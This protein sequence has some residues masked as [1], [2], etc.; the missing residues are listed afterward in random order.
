[1]ARKKV[2]S[3]VM[4][5]ESSRIERKAS[6]IDAEHL[7]GQQVADVGDLL[8]VA[9][10]PVGDAEHRGPEAAADDDRH[11]RLGRAIP[12]APAGVARAPR[13]TWA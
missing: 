2:D 7:A 13:A 1:M 11:Q 6:R 3:A 10:H 12:A 5:L 9:Q 4:T 8:D